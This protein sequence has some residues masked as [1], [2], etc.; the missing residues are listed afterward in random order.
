MLGGTADYLL[1]AAAGV[2]APDLTKA[3]AQWIDADTVVWKVNATAATS[4]QLVYAPDGG[5]SVV[6]GALSDEGQWLRLGATSLTDAQRARFPHLTEYPAFRVDVR[7]RDRIR[8]ALR[9]QLIATQ[10]A[11]NGALLAATGVQTAGVLDSLYGAKA[12]GAALGPVFSKGT[13]TLSVWAPTART[14]QLELDGR[15]VPMR[16]DDTTG[17]WS[18]GERSPGTAS[19]TAT[20]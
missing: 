9:G 11:A 3:E 8:E 1:P 13:P 19:P 10:R 2:P 14:V 12:T 17:V 6:D 15:T 4:Q 16:R 18:V 20:W 5:I 7:D